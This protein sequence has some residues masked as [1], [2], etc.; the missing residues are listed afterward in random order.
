MHTINSMKVETN[1]G[2]VK[3]YG[4]SFQDYFHKLSANV[5]KNL[6]EVTPGVTLPIDSF[7]QWHEADEGADD[8]TY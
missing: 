5:G 4:K 7:G 2:E 8:N 6:N 1:E 3:E